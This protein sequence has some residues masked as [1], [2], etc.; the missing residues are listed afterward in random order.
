MTSQ[1]HGIHSFDE[2]VPK[3]SDYIKQTLGRAH[4]R[5]SSTHNKRK[6]DGSN[7]RSSSQ[8]PK[9]IH[10]AMRNPKDST[11][12]EPLIHLSMW[13][14]NNVVMNEEY[15]ENEGSRRSLPMKQ[16]NISI[17]LW[18]HDIV[19]LWICLYSVNVLCTI[20]CLH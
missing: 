20:E 12:E 10:Q 4:T 3:G 18:F 16:I 8:H 17:Q 7:W 9:K 1:D 2:C 13:I 6:E 14:R 5:R 19:L 15:D 11:L